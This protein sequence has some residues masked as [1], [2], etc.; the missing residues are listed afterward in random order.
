MH[1]TFQRWFFNIE[2]H[3]RSVETGLGNLNEEIPEV[4]EEEDADFELTEEDMQNIDPTELEEFLKNFWPPWTINNT[5]SRDKK[6]FWKHR[7][8]VLIFQ[9][10]PK[11]MFAGSNYHLSS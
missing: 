3:D 6:T 2:F 10:V 8:K 4:V 7:S 11:Y 5:K 9:N 1:K